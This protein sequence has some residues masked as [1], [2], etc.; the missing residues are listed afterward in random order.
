MVVTQLAVIAFLFDLFEILALKL[1]QVAFVFIDS[2][3]QRVEGGAEIKAAAAPTTDVIHSKSLFFELWAVPSWSGQVKPFHEDP[4]PLCWRCGEWSHQAGPCREVPPGLMGKLTVLV[5]SLQSLGK[6][7]GM[8]AFGLGKGF[9]PLG[10]FFE[11]L[12]PSGLSHPRIHL[13]VFVR[14]TFYGSLEVGFGV[15]D[16]H[17]GGR[18]ANLFQKVQMPKGMAGFGF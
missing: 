9:E 16:G 3:K 13:G 6:A 18:I 10:H 5:E 11:P 8:G 12:L 17:V 15:A 7:V 14:F 1:G 4:L 2:I